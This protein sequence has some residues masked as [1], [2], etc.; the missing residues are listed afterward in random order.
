MN[1]TTRLLQIAILVKD[2]PGLT[3]D[4]VGCRVGISYKT[5]HRYLRKLREQGILYVKI[6]HG[7]EYKYHPFHQPVFFKSAEI[8]IEEMN[9]VQRFLAL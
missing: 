6:E 9:K 1:K 3:I 7:S 4:E 8:I 5:A 2:N